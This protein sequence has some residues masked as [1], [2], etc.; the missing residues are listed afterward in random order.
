MKK[1]DRKLLDESLSKA[2]DPPR[3]KPLG[4]LDALLDEYDDQTHPPTVTPRH[5]T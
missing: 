5:P 2:L 3:K 4:N 1:A